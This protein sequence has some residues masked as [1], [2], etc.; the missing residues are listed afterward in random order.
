VY[1]IVLKNTVSC[2]K[3]S[4]F[5]LTEYQISFLILLFDFLW[6]EQFFCLR[7]IYVQNNKTTIYLKIEII[8]H[9]YWMPKECKRP[10]FGHN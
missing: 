1:S 3:Q 6:L 8:N 2:G 10:F 9:P 4:K 7:D 5:Y